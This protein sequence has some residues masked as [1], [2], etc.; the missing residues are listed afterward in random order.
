M[1]LHHCPLTTL[2]KLQ[3]FLA[4][5]TSAMKLGQ[6]FRSLLYSLLYKLLFPTHLSNSLDKLAEL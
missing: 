3:Q 6:A 2:L 1:K 5:F 4:N